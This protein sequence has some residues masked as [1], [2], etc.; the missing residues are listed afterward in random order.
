MPSF[1]SAERMNFPKR[2]ALDA[3]EATRFD[4]LCEGAVELPRRGV[5]RLEE[6]DC[7][8]K[9][10]AAPTDG[11]GDRPDVAAHE[12]AAGRAGDVH[13]GRRVTLASMEDEGRRREQRPSQGLSSDRPVVV[14]PGSVGAMD[15]ADA[16]VVPERQMQN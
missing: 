5:A 1:S 2:D 4:E 13:L 10:W 8:L 14:V 15:G 7:A 16:G 6:Q 12:H 11:D 9:R 3:V